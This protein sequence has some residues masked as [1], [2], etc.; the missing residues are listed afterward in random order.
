M[1]P[2]KLHPAS[3]TRLAERRA[4]ERRRKRTDLIRRL[5]HRSAQ[6]QARGEDDVWAEMVERL[7]LAEA[8]EASE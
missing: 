6:A 2:M 5:E 4:E 8:Q 7:R 1:T 3:I